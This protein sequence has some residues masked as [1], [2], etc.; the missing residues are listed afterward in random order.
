MKLTYD[1]VSFWQRSFLAALNGQNDYLY[2]RDAADAA[3]KWLR[4]RK[5]D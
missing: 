3:I 2:A 1:E 4:E 5:N